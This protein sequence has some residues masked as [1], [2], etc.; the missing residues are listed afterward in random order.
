MRADVHDVV[1]NIILLGACRWRRSLCKQSDGVAIVPNIIIYVNITVDAIKHY[2]RFDTVFVN[3]RIEGLIDRADLV[4]INNRVK[5]QQKAVGHIFDDVVVRE[6]DGISGRAA[7]GDTG[8]SA[9]YPIEY[10]ARHPVTGSVGTSWVGHNP[11]E[12]ITG[13]CRVRPTVKIAV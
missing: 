1:P 7:V 13:G 3:R 6:R 4:V 8:A 9:V 2:N 12:G 11:V 10:A 5:S